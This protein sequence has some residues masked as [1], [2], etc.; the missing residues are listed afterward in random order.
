MA[1]YKGIQGYTVQKLATDPTASEAIGQL[2]Y[3][4]G[5]GKFKIATEGKGA[6]AAGGA[7]VVGR[8]RLGG[9][10]TSTAGLV[11]GGFPPGGAPNVGLTEEYDG[12]TWTE[13]TN[14]PVGTQ[15]PGM[16]GTQT[17]AL[18]ISGG[19]YSPTASHTYNGS[20]WT[21][22][23]T[24]NASGLLRCNGS[25]TQTA[26]LTTGGETHPW[27][28]YSNTTES[29]NGTAWTE[30]AVYPISSSEVQVMGT[31]SAT[32]GVGGHPGAPGN[33]LVNIWNGAS[34][35]AGTNCNTG[36]SEFSS[37]HVGATS[38]SGIIFGGNSPL[39]GATEKWNG[40]SW[41]E[42]GDMATARSQLAGGGNSAA[43]I[44][45]GGSAGGS[46][47]GATEAW[48]DPVY[49]IKTVTVS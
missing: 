15:S 21:A 9:C 28:G 35:T 34:W 46:I 12:S 42:V 44:A 26:A 2:W 6:W 41:T 23:G 33:K 38:T 39:T 49:A 7:M 5:T 17:A 4:S 32:I 10:G 48:A 27:T 30:L 25:G 20:T 3:N 43:A 37:S 11:V 14:Y 45:M 13:V 24:R 47:T 16:A 8:N 19:D 18:F 1:T 31:T 29:Y 22:T 36:R 40:T